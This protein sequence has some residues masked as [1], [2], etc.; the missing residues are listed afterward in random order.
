MA[1]CS[2]VD[3]VKRQK[4]SDGSGRGEEGRGGWLGKEEKGRATISDY[5]HALYAHSSFVRERALLSAKRHVD[6]NPSS[7]TALSAA[8]TA[9]GAYG[10]ELL[11][12]S[13]YTS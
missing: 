2:K 12:T 5:E 6:K 7:F 3:R 1:E 13:E 9:A 10:M 4:Q 11:M 8:I